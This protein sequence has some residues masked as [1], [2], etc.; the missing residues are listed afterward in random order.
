Q[1]PVP[2]GSPRRR[3]LLAVLLAAANE[4]LAAPSLISE[5][6]PEGPPRNALANLRTY[7]SDLRRKLPSDLAARMSTRNGGYRLQVRPGEF[8]LWRMRQAFRTAREALDRADP[9]A[10][11]TGLEPLER[12]LTT[13]GAF[14]GVVAGPILE[15]ARSGIAD[16]CRKVLEA[17]FE[18][19]IMAGTHSD[20][21]AALRSHVRRHPL[22]EHGYALL[23][24][25]L[26]RAGD[27][28]AALEVYRQARQLLVAE[29]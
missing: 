12:A 3:A 6:W 25:A 21:V 9:A 28:A 17:Y 8:D 26:A 5:L 4:T 18:A 29:L 16:E 1:V 10:A 7:A 11:V 2:L 27:N 22:G 13:G 15:A 24:A 19:C 23:M 20:V 14:A